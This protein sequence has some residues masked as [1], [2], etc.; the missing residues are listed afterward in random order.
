MIGDEQKAELN[1]IL[2]QRA[3]GSAGSKMIT[4]ASG[5]GGVGKST[6]T[7]NLAIALSHLGM[8]VLVVD[9]DFGLANIDVMLGVQ[10]KYN[11]SHFIK[12]Q[13][14]LDEIVHIGYDGVRFISGGSGLSELLQLEDRQLARLMKGL[15]RM[16]MPVD[17]ILFDAGASINDNLMQ[18]VLACSETIVVTTP[19]P[20]AIL[21]AYA[22]IKTI[23]AKDIT[24][25]I[26][27]IMNRA[28]TKKEADHVLHGFSEVLSRHLNKTVNCLG[29]IITEPEVPRSIKRQTPMIIA[30]PD[31]HFAKNVEAIARN[32]LELPPAKE[33]T[34]I[35]ARLFSGFSRR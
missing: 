16:D 18:M 27:V 10:T 35:L 7:V 26:N 29:H 5:K 21:D 4:L 24:H 33:P 9:A 2:Y 30:S 17:Y 32:L 25:P 31:S 6:V 15:T 34:G 20:T 28:E 13:R 14:R 23:V 11:L 8:R 22:L 12:G 3:P 19:E 1:N